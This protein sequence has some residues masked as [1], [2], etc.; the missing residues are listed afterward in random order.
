MAVR[1]K[2]LGRGV[3]SVGGATIYTVPAGKTAIV[4]TLTISN[5]VGAINNVVRFSLVDGAFI[6]TLDQKTMASG[7][8]TSFPEYW[9]LPAGGRLDAQST[10]GLAGITLMGVE[11]AGVAP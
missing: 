7:V 2:F 9:V 5:A 1:S 4:K 3:A 11:L 8:A 10:T 6:D